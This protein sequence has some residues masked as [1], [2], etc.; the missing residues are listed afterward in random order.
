MK[1]RELAQGKWRAVLP[2]LGVSKDVLDG[3]HH[4]CPSTGQGE[5]RFRFADRNGS[6]N[7]FCDC[8]DGTKGGLGLVMCCKGIGYAEAAKEVEA[9]VGRAEADP[10]REKRDP[11][12]ALKRVQER[13]K[14]VGFTVRRYLQDRGLQVAPGLRQARLRYWDG[15]KSLGDFD[16]MVGKIVDANGKPQSFHVTYL[17]GAAKANVPS[18]KKVMTPVE[19][20]TGCAIRLYPAAVHIGIAEGIETA[21]AAHLLSGLPVWSVMNAHGIESFDPPAGVEQVTV[22]ADHDETYTGQAAAFAC[23]K[24]LARQGVAVDVRVPDRGDWNDVL[25]GAA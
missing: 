7:Y 2:L 5:D 12:P 8:S 14:P 9:I 25:R 24:R 11:R 10:P 20:I 16:C 3:K 4:P 13:L 1:A 18:S 19:T 17:D 21:I 23:A 22:F 15:P 6:G